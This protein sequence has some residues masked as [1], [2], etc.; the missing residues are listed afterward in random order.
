MSRIDMDFFPLRIQYKFF[1]QNTY[2]STLPMRETIDA[3]RNR[4]KKRQAVWKGY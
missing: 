1:I 3:K 4:E 2:P